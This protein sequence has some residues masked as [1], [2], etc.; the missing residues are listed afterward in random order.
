MRFRNAVHIT[1]DN[2]SSVFKMLLYRIVTWVIF[3]SLTYVIL[4][5]GLGSI[6]SSAETAQ[7][8]ELS[9]EFFRALFGGDAV[10]LQTFHEDFQQALMNFVQLLGA[11]IGSIVGSLIGVCLMYLISRFCNGLSVFAVAGSLNDR[12]SVYSRTSFSASFFRNLGRGSV[13]QLIYVPLAFL[14]DV[15]TFSAC[16]F[17]FFY[18][19]SFMPSWG[20]LT[21]FI[22]LSLSVTLIVVLESLK[23]T[24][25]S[26]WMPAILSD[27][28]RVGAAMRA[29]M[30]AKKNFGKRLASFVI[31]VYLIIAVN[32]V[33][34][35]CTFGSGLLITLPLSFL[36]L[37]G[38]Q[39]VHYYEDNGKKYFI[40]FRKIAGGDPEN[41][42]D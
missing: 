19:P 39:F 6:T 3:F 15:I 21:V 7:L 1:I 25:I 14:Y 16:Y 40:S 5:L 33:F 8:K 37:L 26:A 41:L 31:A 13:Y 36:F 18:A 11:N 24:L 38:L 12:M 10:R 27:G 32:A 29:S 20:I 2:F 34:A 23:M 4:K 17:L 42:N 28:Q 35:L 22:A 30:R 9:L